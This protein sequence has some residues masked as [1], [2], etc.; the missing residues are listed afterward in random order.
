M[1]SSGIKLKTYIK[2]KPTIKLKKIFKNLVKSN[3]EVINSLGK[4]YKYSYNKN[5]I[6]R[7]KK[8]NNFRIIGMGGSSLGSQ[9]IYDFLKYKVKKKFIFVDNLVPAQKKKKKKFV[10]LIIS[11]SGN[12]IETITNSN[13]LIKDKEKNIFITENK[14][15]YLSI[16]AKKLKAEIIHHNNFI[17]GRYSVLSEVGMLP[18]ELMGLKPSKFKQFN[19]LIKN[20]NF[21]KFL[22]SSVV[23]SLHFMKKKNLIP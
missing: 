9:A 20:K 8:N 18:V 7:F 21:E 1:L 19:L 3:L 11:K 5:I 6:L 22:L 23:S 17:G 14:Q 10:N 15:S 4:N 12:T 13:L 2:K 16:L